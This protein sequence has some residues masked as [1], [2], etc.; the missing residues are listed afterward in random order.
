MNGPANS[1]DISQQFSDSIRSTVSHFGVTRIR[2][3]REIVDGRSYM[4]IGVMRRDDPT[5]FT[6]FDIT[7]RKTASGSLDD[8]SNAI[9]SALRKVTPNSTHLHHIKG[10]D[11]DYARSLKLH[12]DGFFVESHAK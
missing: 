3:D 12:S 2:N 5:L 9:V 1:R 7:E 8:F 10:F 6:I 4:C 11:A